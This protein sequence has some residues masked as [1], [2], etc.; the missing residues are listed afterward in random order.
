MTETQIPRAGQVFLDHVGWYVPDMAAA[1]REFDRLGFLLTPYTEH[2]D[3]TADGRS[4]PSGTANRCA[5]LERGYLEILTTVPGIESE[6]TRQLLGGL[7]RYQGV[8]LIAFSAAEASAERL[9]LAQAGF[10]PRPVVNLRRPVVLED[11]ATRLT[12]FSVVRV[13]AERMPEGRIQF[14]THE[15]PEL[16][17]Q[18]GLIARDNAVEA[19]TGILL[20]VDD[21]LEAAD[22]YGRFT[23]RKVTAVGDDAAL[24]VLDRGS[25]AFVRPGSLRRRY[26]AATASPP[27]AAAVGLRSRD[28]DLTRAYLAKRAVRLL[29]DAPDHLI[30]HQDEAAGTAL[31]IHAPGADECLYAC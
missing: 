15:T 28:L 25:I 24:I 3:A 21:M 4:A 1:A 2:R 20:V 6:L 16:V 13:A 7:T 19:L 26:G 9:R 31:V 30:V 10:D 23:D 8:H 11:G 22:R 27:C 29:A 5:M 18:R 12:A 14:L 17:W